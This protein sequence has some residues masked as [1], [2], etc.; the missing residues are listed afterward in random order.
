MRTLDEQK[1]VVIVEVDRNHVIYN[2]KWFIENIATPFLTLKMESVP[3]SIRQTSPGGTTS[4]SNSPTISGYFRLKSSQREF[5]C[6]RLRKSSSVKISTEC[7]CW[8]TKKASSIP[9]SQK[10]ICFP[11]KKQKKTTD[12]SARLIEEFE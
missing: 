1:K 8:D 7:L 9:T 5:N 11:K 12:S 10:S 2:R 4:S 6:F 3:C